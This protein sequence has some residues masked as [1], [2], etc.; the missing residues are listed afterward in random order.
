MELPEHVRN[1]L[2]SPDD[3]ESGPT[4][5]HSIIMETKNLTVESTFELVAGQQDRT[6]NAKQGKRF[7]FGPL[8]SHQLEKQQRATEVITVCPER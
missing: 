7:T 5:S 2:E 3:Q 4:P 8:A 6:R 1:Y